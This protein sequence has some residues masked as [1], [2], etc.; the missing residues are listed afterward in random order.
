MNHSNNCILTFE[1]VSSYFNFEFFD[2]LTLCYEAKNDT[3]NLTATKLI[4]LWITEKLLHHMCFDF[5]EPMSFIRNCHRIHLR[6][7]VTEFVCNRFSPLSISLTEKF[8][9]FHILRQPFKTYNIMYVQF[10]N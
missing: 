10:L 5:H 9:R 6:N 2:H 1:N 4:Q 8:N 7:V 3:E